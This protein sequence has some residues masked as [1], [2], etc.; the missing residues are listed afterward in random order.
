MSREALI[1]WAKFGEVY[2]QKTGF[3]SRP[4]QE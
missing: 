3:R 2:E 1:A 4:S